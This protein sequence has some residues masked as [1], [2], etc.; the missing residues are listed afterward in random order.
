MEYRKI[1]LTGD[2]TYTV[3]LPK[4]WVKKNK[5]D[6]GDVVYVLEEG[7]EIRLKLKETKEKEAQ[8]RIKTGDVEFLSRILIT[9]YIQGYDSV[10]FT[11]KEYI[12]PKIRAHLIKVSSYLIGME[13]FGETRNSITFKMFMKDARNLMESVERM[14]DMSA[15]SLR[16]LIEEL[17][18]ETRSETVLDGI[19]Q[20]D[21]E[22][23]KFYFL[24]LRQLS[25]NN[26]FEAIA[27][28]QIA[29]NIERISDHIET[30]AEL[31]KTKR[32]LKRDDIQLFKQLIDLYGDVMLTMKN[33]DLSMAEEV[34]IKIQKFR[35]TKKS[36]INKLDTV[37]RKN[38]L[39][40]TSFGRIGEYISDIAESV[41]NLS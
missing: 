37:G 34:L 11:A 32:R 26:G 22:I 38:I 21:D 19:I 35:T 25:A 31:A 15:L 3:S 10:V 5:L 30:I 14:Y 41:I 23:D 4:N 33:T 28:S 24:I 1:Q 2:S 20:R 18:S 17:E 16:E 8:Y 27:R 39:I 40:Y 36:I 29:K 12:D 9:K 13:P 7:G 6:K